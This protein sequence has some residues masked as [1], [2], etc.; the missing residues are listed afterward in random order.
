MKRILGIFLSCLFLIFAMSSC[1]D[2]IPEEEAYKYGLS[3]GDMYL[4]TYLGDKTEVVIPEMYHGYYV[5]GIAYTFRNNKYVY[6]VTIPKT[7]K[8]IDTSAFE[9]SVVESVIFKDPTG[10]KS[11]ATGQPIPEEKL[12]NTYYAVEYLKTSGDV[13]YKSTTLG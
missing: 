3:G 8:Y 11:V 4:N 1:G 6:K 9:N 12:K 7:V 5:R 10:W 2:D 13:L